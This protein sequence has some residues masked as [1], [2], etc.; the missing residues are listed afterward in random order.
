MY[1]LE[2]VANWWITVTD[3]SGIVF[4]NIFISYTDNNVISY[5]PF[6][7][8]KSCLYSENLDEYITAYSKN[9]QFITLFTTL[10][11]LEKPIINKAA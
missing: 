9:V 8:F 3:K 2:N 11:H 10:K 4:D 6:K 7:R 5:L 1:N